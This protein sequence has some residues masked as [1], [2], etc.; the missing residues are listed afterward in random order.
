MGPVWFIAKVM[1]FM[2]LFVWLR[3]TLPRLRYDQFMHLGWKVLIP[4]NLVWILAVA[5]ARVGAAEEWFNATFILIAAGVVIVLLA[6]LLFVPGK[7][8]DV[9]SEVSR[10]PFTDDG[11]FDPFEGGYPVPPMPGQILPEFEDVLVEPEEPD[12]L[13]FAR[14][15]Q[16]S[17]PGE[18]GEE[19]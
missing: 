19:E 1:C 14:P 6:V 17:Q 10:V 2:F 16:L 3:G 9:R 7:P 8:E 12:E 4:A 15:D 18:N 5:F 13:V 11:V